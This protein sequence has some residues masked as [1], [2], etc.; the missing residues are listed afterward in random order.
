MASARVAAS[1]QYTRGDIRVYSYT[2]ETAW[3]TWNYPRMC[4]LP[5]VLQVSS[6][7]APKCHGSRW[8]NALSNRCQLPAFYL[9]LCFLLS[10]SL[11]FDFF[12]SNRLDYTYVYCLSCRLSLRFSVRPFLFQFFSVFTFHLFDG[13]LIYSYFPSPF[14]ALFVVGVSSF[15]G[16]LVRCYSNFF[17]LSLLPFLVPFVIR[18]SLHIS[19]F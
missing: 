9:H 6:R 16:F 17:Y 19:N 11:S 14:Y 8:F 4:F 1:L 10:F 13:Y 15:R 5:H 18:H 2:T 7:F 3:P 12:G